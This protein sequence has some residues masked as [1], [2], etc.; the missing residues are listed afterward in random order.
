MLISL[1]NTGIVLDC[2][3]TNLHMFAFAQE[4]SA[5]INLPLSLIR[6]FMNQ[7]EQG[8]ELRG[9]LAFRVEEAIVVACIPR[10]QTKDQLSQ[11]TSDW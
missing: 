2:T 1:M 3:V 4:R 6:R 10:S 7:T 5:Q 8:V 11:P 9:Q